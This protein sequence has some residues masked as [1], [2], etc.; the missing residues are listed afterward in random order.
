MSDVV[1]VVHRVPD[2]VAAAAFFERVLWMTRVD[3]ERLSSGAL[4]LRLL[5]LGKNA[6]QHLLEIEVATASAAECAAAL[7][8]EPNATL[9]PEPPHPAPDRIELVVRMRHGVVVRVV[10]T[11]DEDDLGVL[12][13]LPTSLE[14]VPEAVLLVQTTLRIVPIAFRDLARVRMTERA[15]YEACRAGAVEVNVALAVHGMLAAT[16][17]FQ[18]AALRE[19]LDEAGVLELADCA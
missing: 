10:H 6:P 17:P 19:A 7:L 2:V 16:P 4:E 15:E 5:P 13:P 14:W 8:K 12:P 3:D 11:L 18:L 9:L 1:A